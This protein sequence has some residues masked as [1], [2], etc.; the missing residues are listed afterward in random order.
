[1]AA[2]SARMPTAAPLRVVII[3]AGFG[4]LYAARGLRRAP[5][6][7][8]LIDRHNYHLFQ[9][10]LYQVATGGLA[11]SDIA[12][13]IRAVLSRQKNARVLLAEA[14]AIDA[15]QRRVLLRDGS[16][17]YDVLIVA[18]G[19]RDSYFQHPEWAPL[20]P[21]LKT[22]EGA[23]TMRRRILLAF[24]HAEREA[25]PSRRAALLRFVIVGGGPTGV[26]LAGAIAEIAQRVLV[27]DFRA[28]DPR[29]TEVIL[30][31]AGARILPAFPAELSAKAQAALERLG[32]VVRTG[33]TVQAIATGSVTI[34]DEACAAATVLWAAGVR[35]A[36]L[37]ASLGVPLVQGGR[38]A[39][40][41]DLSLAGR[42][43]IY[44]IGD[45]ALALDENGR[46]LPGIAPVALQQGRHVAANLRRRL[47][48]Q[49]ERA[50][51]YVDKGNLATIGRAAAVAD[52]RGWC[53]A[54]FPAWLIWMLVHIFFLIGFRNRLVV[55]LDWA[56]AYLRFERAARLIVGE[57][58][59]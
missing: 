39:V 59:Q 26:E 20:A 5:V 50:F 29:E 31:E 42:P 3:G 46:P 1:M 24:E 15:A 6:A 8:T 55:A 37:V 49:P 45:A 23:L 10:L 27:Q 44:V 34:A 19:A 41:P 16:V 25:D 17:A 38:V 47:Q 9:P 40:R 43:E 11:P 52:I 18:P 53:F 54:G 12:Y 30:V 14:T 35:A 48:G 58:E 32:V 13:P 57:P 21:G 28:V 51:H 33:A 4:G 7:V 22:L 56:W 2:P 36:S